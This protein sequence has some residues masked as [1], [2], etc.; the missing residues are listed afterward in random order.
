MYVSTV[1]RVSPYSHDYTTKIYHNKILNK[2][3]KY[4]KTGYNREKKKKKKN[5]S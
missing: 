3:L 1:W 2:N 4:E 5:Q